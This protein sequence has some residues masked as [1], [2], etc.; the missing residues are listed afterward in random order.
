VFIKRWSPWIALLAICTTH[1]PARASLD[2][3][4]QTVTLQ[5]TAPGDDGWFGQA[6]M[7]DVRYSRTP[8]TPSNYMW[9]T[10]VPT[11]LLPGAAGTK[12]S[13]T[14]LG[15]T[16]GLDYYFAVRAIDEAGNWSQISNVA[17]VLTAVQQTYASRPALVTL[18]FDQP[19]PNPSRGDTRFAVQLP[20]PSWMRVEAF[21]VSGRK[22]R[23]IAMGQYAAGAFDLKWDLRDDGGRRLQP[24]TYM[25]RGQVGE[26]VFLRRVTVMN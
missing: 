2:G 7:Y 26:N 9:A 13:L 17:H 12:Q 19:R 15:L 14:V 16:P 23:T 24:G 10:R 4:E 20:N 5:W 11:T 22:I 18:D 3:A 6:Y 21:D 1:T 25:V 8:I